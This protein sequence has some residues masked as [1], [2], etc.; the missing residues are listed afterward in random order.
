MTQILVK[1]K[2]DILLEFASFYPR[3]PAFSPNQ[4]IPRQAL[5]R[6]FNERCFLLTLQ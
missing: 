2:P 6:K 5:T 3:S 1:Y 4:P